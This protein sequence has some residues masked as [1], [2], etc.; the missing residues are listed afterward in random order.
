MIALTRIRECSPKLRTLGCI[1]FN[2]VIQSTRRRVDIKIHLFSFQSTFSI[3]YLF[4]RLF[5]FLQESWRC[6]FLGLEANAVIPMHVLESDLYVTLDIKV[7][8]MLHWI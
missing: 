4:T 2:F 7:C 3:H 6:N 5:N 8:N 1:R